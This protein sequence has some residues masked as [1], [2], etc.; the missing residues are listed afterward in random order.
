MQIIILRKLLL[1]TCP[2]FSQAYPEECYL[3]SPLE[4]KCISVF[5]TLRALSQ[6]PS[7]KLDTEKLDQC[8]L[9]VHHIHCSQ[10]QAG[11]FPLFTRRFGQY[12]QLILSTIAIFR[13]N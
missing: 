5:V 3:P 6:L 8:S 11:Y 12:A 2:A 1:T 9:H 10:L 4:Y 7:E 13:T